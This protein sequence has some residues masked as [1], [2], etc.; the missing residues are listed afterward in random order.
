M[1]H[2]FNCGKFAE[3]NYCDW[4]CHI[5]AARKNGFKEITPNGLPISCIGHGVMMEHP[6]ADHPTYKFPVEAEYIGEIDND[7]RSDYTLFNQVVGTD[8][9]VRQS[10]TESHALIYNDRSI[11]ITIY[12]CCYAMWYLRGGKL[13]GGSLWD[14]GKW[15]LTEQS[16][17]N[18]RAG[19]YTGGV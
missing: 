6:D 7:L 4:D 5:E 11:A 14:K 15:R 8:E 17:K 16:I 3:H 12:E 19:K 13:G 18:I 2:C 10:Q 1:R 9:D